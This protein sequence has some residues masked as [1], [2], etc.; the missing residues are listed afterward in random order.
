MWRHFITRL[1]LH[2]RNKTLLTR[3]YI[4]ES[5]RCILIGGGEWG[6]G[7]GRGDNRFYLFKWLMAQRQPFVGG[8]FK[9][10][11]V[12][13]RHVAA[14]SFIS[15]VSIENKNTP[16]KGPLEIWVADPAPTLQ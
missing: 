15:L 10:S 3:R 16:Q 4:P 5:L 13:L 11:V 7:W 14:C 6:K 12:F 2:P 1:S 9:A 8:R